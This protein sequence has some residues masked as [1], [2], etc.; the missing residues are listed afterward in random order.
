[1]KE[2]RMAEVSGEC[3]GSIGSDDIAA[4][5][6]VLDYPHGKYWIGD[7]EGGIARAESGHPRVTLL[8]FPQLETRFHNSGGQ[9]W[10]CLEYCQIV[11]W[12]MELMKYQLF[13]GRAMLVRQKKQNKFWTTAPFVATR[14]GTYSSHEHF[15][16]M[17]LFGTSDVVRNYE[18]K[19]QQDM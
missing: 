12:I 17:F 13:R 3:L 1:M 9:R 8:D 11:A 5:R 18:T 16:P 7:R 19:V 2:I 14:K 4:R 10:E 6:M 15:P